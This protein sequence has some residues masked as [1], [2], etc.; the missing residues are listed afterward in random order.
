MDPA[1]GLRLIKL[2]LCSIDLFNLMKFILSVLDASMLRVCSSGGTWK[3]D[4]EP[5]VS[6]NLFSRRR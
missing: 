2:D 5:N 4:G 3:L 6:I 1:I